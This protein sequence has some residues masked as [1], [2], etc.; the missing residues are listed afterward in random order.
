MEEA[1]KQQ[2]LSGKVALVTG[3]AGGIGRCI[4]E[5]LA[6]K[7]ADIIILDIAVTDECEAVV[8]C[9]N[10][11]VRVM[12]LIC[13][14]TSV[15]S[16]EE[17]VDRAVHTMGHIDILVN[18]AGVY[19]AAPVL[20]VTKQQF[21]FVID[22]NLK[23]LFFITQAVIKK[24]MLPNNYGRIVNISSSDGK[25]PGKGVSIYGA[26]KA[27]VISLTKSFA[28]ELAGYDIN[29]NAV[30][31]GWVESKQVLAN[32]RW[33]DVLSQIPSQRLGRLSEIAEAVAFLCSDRVSYINGE[34]LD[35][36]GGLLMD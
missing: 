21:D 11:G 28:R 13:N 10:K 20:E 34:I 15:D 3:A 23:G 31:P 24:S 5:N 25:N 1:V 32:D 17:A 18:N 4:A 7:G 14:L 33:K 26:A 6:E 22:V 36:N 27:G 29:A 16:I 8:F 12:P 2:E 19:P 35:V 9:R 30:A